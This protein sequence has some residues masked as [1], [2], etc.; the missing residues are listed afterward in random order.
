MGLPAALNREGR[1]ILF[2]TH[3]AKFARRARRVVELRDG[4]VAR[5]NGVAR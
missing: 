4:R 1:T 2:V 5:A 3:D